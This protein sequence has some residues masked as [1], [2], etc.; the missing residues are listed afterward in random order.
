MK[1]EAMRYLF[2]LM[3]VSL[4]LV[5]AQEPQTPPEVPEV[6]EPPKMDSTAEAF[7][8]KAVTFASNYLT[9][10]EKFT[11]TE[12]AKFV[13]DIADIAEEVK[14]TEILILAK[15]LIQHHM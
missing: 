12:K 4:C 6:P 3:L 10:Q 2:I 7:L 9:T 15:I 8:N 13:N 14:K 1:G 11:E 5:C